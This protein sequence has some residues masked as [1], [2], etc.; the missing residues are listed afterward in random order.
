[1]F[2]QPRYPYSYHSAKARW[3]EKRACNLVFKAHRLVHHSTLGWRVIK[4]IRRDLVC[5]PSYLRLIDSST[6]Q[7]KAQGPSRT[8]NESKKEEA[9]TLC[10]APLLLLYSRYRS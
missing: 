7:L 3:V 6:T 8:C 2:L 5:S 4:Q 1:M 10:A 9:H